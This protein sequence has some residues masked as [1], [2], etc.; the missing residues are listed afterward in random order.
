VE[1]T[2]QGRIKVFRLAPLQLPGN[3]VCEA[4]SI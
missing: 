3:A 4:H 2:K 1:L